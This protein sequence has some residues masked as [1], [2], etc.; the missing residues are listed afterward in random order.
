MSRLVVATHNAHKTA[1]I[2]EAL[3]GRFAE[4]I[5]L[6]A[7]PEIS[8][9]IEDGATFEANARI[10]ALHAAK[11]LPGD[12]VLADDSGLEVDALNGEPGVFSARYASENAS[13]A[14]NRAKLLAALESAE[15]RSARFR[16][17]LVLVRGEEILRV[18]DGTV[19]GEIAQEERGDGGFGYDPVFIPEGHAE[20][21]GELPHAVKQSISHRARALSRFVQ[22]K[23]RRVA[24]DHAKWQMKG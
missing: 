2:R 1:E 13:D 19:E 16:C 21:F 20:T 14:E 17:V 5:D 8:P 12:T 24:T 23:I 10:K 4:I 6:N 18:C 9:A 3:A 11:A 7:F 22:E 15:A